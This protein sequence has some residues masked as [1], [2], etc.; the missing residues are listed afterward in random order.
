LEQSKLQVSK[1]TP[2]FSVIQ[3]V[4]I[5]NVRSAPKRSLIVLTYTFIGFVLGCG[6][7]LTKVPLSQILKEIRA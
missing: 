5:P 4:T 2:V 3:P 1:D 7:V 6:F